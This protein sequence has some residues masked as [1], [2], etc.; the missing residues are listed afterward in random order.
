MN[1]VLFRHCVGLTIVW[2]LSLQS[3]LAETTVLYAHRM[4]DV[5]KG[6]MLSNPVLVIE[7]DRIVSINPEQVPTEG[8]RLNWDDVTLLPGLIDTHTH[9]TSNRE[10]DW[11]H[12]AVKQGPADRAL[13]G[14]RGAWRTLMAGFTTVRDLG[15][16]GFADVALMEAIDSGLLAGPRIIPSGHPLG[17]TGGHCDITGYR[18]GILELGPKEGVADGVDQVIQAVRYQI[19]HGAKVIKTCATAGVFSFEGPVGAQQYSDTELSAMVQEAA[20]HGV[21]VAAHAHGTEGILAATRAGVASI[22]HGSVLTD[23]AIRLMKSKGTYL[24][25]TAYLVDVIK[26]EE[27]PPPIRAKSEYLKPLARKSLEQAIQAGVKIAFGTDAAV[28][29]HGDNAHEFGTLVNRGMSELEALRT[30]TLYAADLLGVPD[31]GVLEAG[32]LADLVAVPGNP[33]EDIRVMERVSHV[34]KG[35]EVVKDLWGPRPFG[36]SA[37][38]ALPRVVLIGDSIRM[39]YQAVVKKALEG[40]AQIWAPEDNCRYAAYTLEHL[41]EWVS[42][43]RPDVVHLNVGLH[44]MY[45]MEET[46]APRTSIE[47]YGKNLRKILEGITKET[48]AILILALTTPVHE[49]WQEVS[50]GYGRVVRRDS[51]V[52]RY[53]QVARELAEEFSLPVNDLYRVIGAVGKEKL[54]TRDGVHFNSQGSDRLGNAVSAHIRDALG[55][56]SKP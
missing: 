16:R 7:D 38:P 1:R 49:Q 26:T 33:L 56:H 40:E 14:V 29:P 4:L 46:G 35:G 13:A 15:A 48:S 45:L 22:E 53:N 30:A 3:G 11:V 8:R 27:L 28:F 36:E 31:R 50:E 25:P 52:A 51:D 21:K 24:V 9:L 39:G 43:R 6:E 54:M 34:I 41:D 20:R 44:D 19:K 42:S 23:E 37:G 17:I 5:V 55:S 2:S 12:R 32:R 18:P 47:D 10:G